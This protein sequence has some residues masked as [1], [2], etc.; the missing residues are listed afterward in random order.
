M[1]TSSLHDFDLRLCEYAVGTVAG[2][3]AGTDPLPIADGQLLPG[4]APGQPPPVLSR[5]RDYY[6]LS[7]SVA[8]ATALHRGLSPGL[9]SHVRGPRWDVLKAGENVSGRPPLLLTNQDFEDL[10]SA[11][12]D[13]PGGGSLP[14]TPWPALHGDYVHCLREIRTLA[15]AAADTFAEQSCRFAEQ[16]ASPRLK[17][18]DGVRLVSEWVWELRKLL[19]AMGLTQLLP[20][21]EGSARTPSFPDAVLTWNVARIAERLEKRFRE[22]PELARVPKTQLREIVKGKAADVFAA[23]EYLRSRGLYHPSRFT[24]EMVAPA[25]VSPPAPGQPLASDVAGGRL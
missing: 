6:R 18:P 16:L 4:A 10:A 17:L 23:L 7:P 12:E 11:I 20:R 2:E 8:R 5:A 14:W 15:K 13:A 19:R 24:I 9:W 1:K 3:Y 21:P 25:K 22:K